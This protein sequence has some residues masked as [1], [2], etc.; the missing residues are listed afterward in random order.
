MARFELVPSPSLASTTRGSARQR[1]G[2]S[3]MTATSSRILEPRAN[4]AGRPL[5]ADR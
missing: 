4:A 3:V 2:E 1:S 5:D